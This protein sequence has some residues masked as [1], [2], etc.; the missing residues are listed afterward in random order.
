AS[1]QILFRNWMLRAFLLPID[2]Y[3]PP[4][5]AIV[6]Q[7]YAVDS[8]NERF[9]IVRVMTRFIH[10]PDVSDMSELFGAPGNFLLVKSIFGKIRFHAGDETIYVQNLRRETVVRAR[11]R[12]RNQARPWEK[13]GCF[14]IPIT[15]LAG[16]A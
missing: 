6:K 3:D 7:L 9:G 11:L 13:Q 14:S 16:R 2:V 4:A 12:G 1:L 8:A 15:L 5:I 10:A